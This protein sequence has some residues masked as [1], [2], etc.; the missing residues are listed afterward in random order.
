MTNAEML[1]A[2][3]ETPAAACHLGASKG[4]IAKGFNTDLVAL[5]GDPLADVS[6]LLRP[7]NV[8]RAGEPTSA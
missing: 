6:S 8:I 4:R 1:R 3:T 7:T 5:D 2:V